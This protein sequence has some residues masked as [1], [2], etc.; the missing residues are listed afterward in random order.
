M[1]KFCES[2]ADHI[3]IYERLNRND[4]EADDFEERYCAAIVKRIFR[5]GDDYSRATTTDPGFRHYADGY[6][7]NF[8]PEC[9]RSLN[10]K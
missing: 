10:E 5:K 8:C 3:R 2:L 4:P 7:L 9:G 6:P 1:C